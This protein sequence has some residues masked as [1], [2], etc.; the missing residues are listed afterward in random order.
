MP[1]ALKA[2]GQHV[3]Q[4]PPYELLA[5]HGAPPLVPAIGILLKTACSMTANSGELGGTKGGIGAF[6]APG[7]FHPLR[8]QGFR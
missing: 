5:C 4:K 3:L 8:C 1:H 7:E 6:L 2:C